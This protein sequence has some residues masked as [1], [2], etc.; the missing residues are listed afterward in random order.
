MPENA[1]EIRFQSI[2]CKNPGANL[3]LSTAI[4][5][6]YPYIKRKT[7]ALNFRTV[8]QLLFDSESTAFS[9]EIGGA[10]CYEIS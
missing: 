8:K 6:Q 4:V 1:T 2:N 7:V 5:L 3:D 10:L 9:I